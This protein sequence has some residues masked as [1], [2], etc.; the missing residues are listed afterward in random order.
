[1]YAS[2][3]TTEYERRFCIYA[4]ECAKRA[5]QGFPI[6]R[7]SQQRLDH[8]CGQWGLQ[9]THVA[10]I[11][12]KIFANRDFLWQL[13]GD[14]GGL[15][16]VLAK[17]AMECL[18]PVEPQPGQPQSPLDNPT[19]IAVEPAAELPAPVPEITPQERSP[20]PWWG[21]LWIAVT[22]VG[23]GAIGGG[24]LLVITGQPLDEPS[25]TPSSG[26]S[27]LPSSVPTTPAREGNE[28]LPLAPAPAP[29]PSEA[30]PFEPAPSSTTAPVT[31]QTPADV[32]RDR[33]PALNLNA[34][35]FNQLHQNVTGAN[36]WETMAPPEQTRSAHKLL[37]T[38]E[39]G[40]SQQAIGKLGSYHINQL[41]PRQLAL[42]PSTQFQ[43]ELDRLTDDK[44]FQ[45]FPDWRGRKLPGTGLDQVWLGML[46]D[47]LT[48][49]EQQQ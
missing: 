36:R 46:D 32:V 44:F 19:P 1:M 14:I 8:L 28:T 34:D 39:K 2:D 16:A 27:P 15:K 13:S 49:R 35:F 43:K 29:S 24:A 42:S 26:A 41:A 11:D 10:E 22:V 6:S 25:A 3:D 21:V 37:D 38:L 18:Y 31:N 48:A 45:L 12:E 5:L 7:E 23:V 20:F 9:A 33:L 4:F 17:M 40:L 47:V 30:A